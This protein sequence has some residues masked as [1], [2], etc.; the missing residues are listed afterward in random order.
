MNVR[1]MSLPIQLGM[2]GLVVAASL[3]PASLKAQQTTTQQPQVIY[4]CVI[5]GSGV[6]YLVNGPNDPGANPNLPNGCRSPKHTLVH[7][8]VQGPPGPQGP[9]GTSGS[10]DPWMVYNFQTHKISG[11]GGFTLKF[12]EVNTLIFNYPN[13]L[14]DGCAIVANWQGLNQSGIPVSWAANVSTQNVFGDGYLTV[15]VFGN[16]PPNM[17]LSGVKTLQLISRC[18]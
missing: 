17:L 6:V 12:N 9:A 15:F 4:A 18:P 1:S 10:S 14:L 3:L 2:T 7:W 13:G 8:S 5:K 16:A 11:S